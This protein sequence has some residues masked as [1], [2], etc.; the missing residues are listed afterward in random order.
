MTSARFETYGLNVTK[1]NQQQYDAFC[2]RLQEGGIA[3]DYHRLTHKESDKRLFLTQPL[4]RETVSTINHQETLVS[5]QAAERFRDSL[6]DVAVDEGYE[7]LVD[8]ER[9]NETLGLGWTFSDAPYHPACGEW[10]GKP[11]L[12]WVRKGLG[13]RLVALTNDLLSCDYSLH[14]EDAFRPTGVQE[15]LFR[16]RYTMAHDAQPTWS[17][18]DRLLEAQSKTAFTPRFAAHKAGAAADIR[19][20][21]LRTG[22]LLEIG[23][24]Y[25][26]GGET[27][28][29]DS[30]YVTQE[31]WQNRK[32][33]QAVA[34]RA[35]LAMYP[36]EDW[37]VSVN[38]VTAAVV[39]DRG[40]SR[41]T[42]GPIK[43]FDMT[44]GNITQTYSTSE[45]DEVFDVS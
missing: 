24:D 41:V 43:E 40:T 44:S 29:L 45:L 42:Y 19:I 32:L 1:L 22:Y 15:G 31:Q 7:A 33:L 25:P 9:M 2:N 11:R 36:F 21:D 38:D 34:Q 4:S 28:R 5:A 10:A 14:F 13:R 37:H 26:D 30:L 23:H 6:C 8:L 17:H 12:M 35:G 16:R 3:D 18:E 27:V 20:R 39:Q